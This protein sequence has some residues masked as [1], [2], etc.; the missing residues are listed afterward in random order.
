MANTVR[1]VGIRCTLALSRALALFTLFTLFT[2]AHV[3]TPTSPVHT[4]TWT[5]DASSGSISNG[6]V[7]LPLGSLLAT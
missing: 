6:P 5:T 7:M 2:L 4:A 1:H 3:V